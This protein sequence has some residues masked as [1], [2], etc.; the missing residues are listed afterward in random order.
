MY[1][2][3]RP[4]RLR[5]CRCNGAGGRPQQGTKY[6]V[7]LFAKNANEVVSD[8]GPE[9]FIAQS[10]P[11]AN[12]VFADSVNTDGVRLNATGGSKRRPHLDTTGSM[13]RRKPTGSQTAEKRLRRETSTE[14][15]LPTS[16]VQPFPVS[17]L[18]V[19]PTGRYRVPLPSRD[20]KR[21]GDL[22]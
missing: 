4:Q 13:G 3:Q 15:E 9:Q 5:R 17:D 20:P 14:T 7:K 11:I 16:L 2:G 1:R 19:G 18:V 8:G 10:K 12:P 6:W 21:T 22:G